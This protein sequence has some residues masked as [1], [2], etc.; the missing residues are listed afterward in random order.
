MSN[1][2]RDT[3]QSGFSILTLMS[4][5]LF[6]S[7]TLISLGLF[8]F[9]QISLENL[10]KELVVEQQRKADEIANKLE[11]YLLYAQQIVNTTAKLIAPIQ[12]D[13]KTV[14]TLLKRIL[15]SA[16]TETI[17][18]IGV[19]YEPYQFDPQVKY[20]GPY[21]HRD[22]DNL[23]TT[24]LT[25]EWTTAEYDFHQQHW[26]RLGMEAQGK[27][28][29]S[30]PYFDTNLI[31]M[32]ALVSFDHQGSETLGIVSVD[33]VLPQLSELILNLN[34]ENEII[35]VSTAKNALLVHPQQ[36]QL[37][38]YAAQQDKTASHLLDLSLADLEK[39]NQ[40]YPV[41][42]Q[43]LTNTTQVA[44]VN[45]TV[46]IVANKEIL[47]SNVRQL[48]NTILG[49][50]MLLW[51][52]VLIGI[53]LLSRANRHTHDVELKNEQLTANN[54][55]LERRVEERT[56][57]LQQAYAEIQDLNEQLTSEN[58]RMRA[59]LDISH[60]LQQMLLPKEDELQ[61]IN[62][63]DIA[64]FMQ[65]A[66][67]V[68]GDY[69]DVLQ[70][71][72]KVKI[73]IGDVTGHGLE[74]SVLMLMVQ[75]AVRTLLVHE[76]SDVIRFFRT[77]NRIIYDNVQ[78]MKSDKNLSLALLDYKDGQLV[79]SGQH[80]EMLVIRC[81]GIVERIDTIDLGFPIGLEQ[82]ITPFINQHKVSLQV[83]DVVIL[84]TDGVTEAENQ[85]KRLYGLERLCQIAQQCRMKSAQEIRQTIVEDIQD[86]IDEMYDDITLVIIKQK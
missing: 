78:R 58:V 19:W 64:G 42:K 8:I 25:Y 22:L 21:V 65:P 77:L 1:L 4:S 3:E 11:N 52:V 69:Y 59:E 51:L 48:G 74:S 17:Y 82:E 73:G 62:E 39:F 50:I 71:N 12:Q 2:Q 55:E 54:D 40:Q 72:G 5:I 24:V 15:S 31:Y 60:R 30:E 43:I 57:A 85:H 20:F 63:L 26:Y 16:P 18:G 23:Q 33:M 13:T 61:L 34:N 10:Q 86:Y 37:L 49:V 35:Y 83:G 38:Q 75:T 68:G 56:Q 9:Y 47:M 84:Y 14:E 6:I 76:E 32:S 80:E 70:Y 27:L 66:C 79:L 44:G 28:V 46:H 53:P 29:F 67:E 36:Q 41:F 45:W 7:T 81:N